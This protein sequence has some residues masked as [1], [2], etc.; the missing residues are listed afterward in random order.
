MNFGC[1]VY[2]TSFDPAAYQNASWQGMRWGITETLYR[3][4][5]DS[6]IRPWLSDSYEV[7]ED[8][9]TWTFHIRDGVKFSNGSPC[10]AQAVADSMNRL[11]EVCN[12]TEYSSTPRQYIDMASIEADPEANT[13]TIVT[14]TA[15]ADLRG[16]LC[17]PFYTIIDVEGI[18]RMRSIRADT[19]HLSS[20]RV[21]MS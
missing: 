19:P 8:H 3:F 1:Y 21:L 2:S 15:Y 17:F 14:N 13:V 4:N 6:T 11:F 5:D 12:S 7:S 10:D 18:L 16:P 20:A 9:K